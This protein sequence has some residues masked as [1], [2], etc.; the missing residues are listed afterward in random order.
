[1]LYS[2]TLALLLLSNRNHNK[3]LTVVQKPRPLELKKGY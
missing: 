1:M 3:Q 2:R